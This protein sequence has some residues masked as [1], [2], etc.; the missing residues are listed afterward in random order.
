MRQ[1]PAQNMPAEGVKH[2]NFLCRNEAIPTPIPP[3]PTHPQPAQN[4]DQ[5]NDPSRAALSCVPTSWRPSKIIRAQH[6]RR[7][8]IHKATMKIGLLTSGG[9]C[10]G[11]NAVIRRCRAQRCQEARL[12]I[13]RLPVTAGEASSR[14]N[15]W[16]C[17][18]RRSAACTPGRYHRGTSPYQPLDGP[19]GGPETLRNMMERHGI[20]ATSS[21]RR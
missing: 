15:T 9:D 5:E 17:P 11:L 14:A 16:T 2:L 10:P 1:A 12:R 4:R 18:A 8:D 21:Y 13:R 6:T 20:D 19:N 7:A 3:L